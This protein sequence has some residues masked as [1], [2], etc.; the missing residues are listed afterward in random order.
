MDSLD[1]DHEIDELEEEPDFEIIAGNKILMESPNIIHQTIRV[2][3][4]YLFTSY[5]DSKNIK[6]IVICSRV[7]VHLSDKN[8][9]MPDV[10][11]ICD[12]KTVENDEFVDGAPDLVVEVLSESTKQYDIGAKKDAY[13]KYGVKEYWIVDPS[14][15]SIK[16]YH[17]VDGKFN[18]S[19]EYQVNG[20]KTEIKVSIFDDLI[21]NIRKVFKWWLD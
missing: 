16:V 12:L 21:V 11:I 19:G 8:Q 18:L 17:N 5:I 14:D 7:D 6:A 13:E 1:Y 4:G 2:R 3:L 9:F 20:D 15:R 10:I